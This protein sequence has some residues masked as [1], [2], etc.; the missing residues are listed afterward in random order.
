MNDAASG[1][2]PNNATIRGGIVESSKFE[3]IGP[4]GITWPTH[5]TI[6]LK[7]LEPRHTVLEAPAVNP[8]MSDR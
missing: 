5:K 8:G 1:K 4:E 6:P 7:V 2:S 3:I